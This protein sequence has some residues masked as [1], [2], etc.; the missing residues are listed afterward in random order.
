MI[1]WLC[2]STIDNRNIQSFKIRRK[3]D[4]INKSNDWYNISCRYII[5]SSLILSFFYFIQV[6]LHW[7]FIFNRLNGKVFNRIMN[8][9][10]IYVGW[11]T[12]SIQKQFNEQTICCVHGTRHIHDYVSWNMLALLFFLLSF[13]TIDCIISSLPLIDPLLLLITLFILLFATI[14][15]YSQICRWLG[16]GITIMCAHIQVTINT[17]D[18]NKEKN[19]MVRLSLLA[20]SLSFSN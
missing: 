18:R 2:P 16:G 3:A 9:L 4:R 7:W 17:V 20:A 6:Y 11:L 12:V 13:S 19:R 5:F 8:V 14:L 10:P 15:L 1:E